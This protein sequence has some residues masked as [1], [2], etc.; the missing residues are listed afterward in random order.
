LKFLVDNA[1]SPLIAE[2][3][4]SAGHNAIHIRDYNMQKATDLEVFAR[5][6]AE[7]RI[8]ISADTDFG[9]LLALRNEEKPSVILLRR[10]PKRPAVQ[11][12]LLIG[13]MP[14]M[15]EPLSEG[16]I[17]VVEE[18]RIRVRRLPLGRLE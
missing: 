7:D 2:G 3:L 6:A 4:R 12:R 8:L 13:A 10:G 1:L 9:T 18:K 14:V 5:A 15:E 11:L 16:S 17:I